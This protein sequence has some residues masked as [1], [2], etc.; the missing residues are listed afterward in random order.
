MPGRKMLSRHWMLVLLLS[1][2]GCSPPGPAAPPGVTIVAA[3]GQVL[4]QGAPAADADIVFL[5]E[6]ANISATAKSG[7]DGRFQL[8]TLV[9]HDGA[10]VGSH[11]V[12]IRKVEVIDKT[13]PGLDVTAGQH[14][15]P[16]EIKWLI[17]EKYSDFAKSDLKAEVNSAGPNDF[18]FDLK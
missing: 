13:P 4:F 11:K 6:Q 5:N 16:P 1:A 3:G 17:P 18:K 15:P 7:S 12:A 8:T 2:F 14:A 10:A 9:S